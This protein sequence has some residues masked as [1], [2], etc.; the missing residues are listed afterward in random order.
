MDK[1]ERP[2]IG[3][4]GLHV[5]SGRDP[6]DM[7]GRDRYAEQKVAEYFSVTHYF[8]CCLGLCEHVYSVGMFTYRH[9]LCRGHACSCSL[10]FL[11]I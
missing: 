3:V 10:P 6:N 7:R 5:E 1:K 9:S 8:T 4:A 11:Y 2:D